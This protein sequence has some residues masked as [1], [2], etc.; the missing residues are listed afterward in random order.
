MGRNG[1][2]LLALVTGIG[3]AGLLVAGTTAALALPN[4]PQVTLCHATPPDTAAQGYVE[5]TVD[6]NAVPGKNLDGGGQEILDNGCVAAPAPTTTA[7]P[8]TTTDA[9][10]PRTIPPNDNPDRP[11]PSGA[12]DAGGGGLYGQDV[13]RSAPIIMLVSGGLLLAASSAL[14]VRWRRYSR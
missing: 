9:P 11:I 8:P 4:E 5:I 1:T 3:A 6:A 13:N 10:P 7:P 14:T 2:A 12:V